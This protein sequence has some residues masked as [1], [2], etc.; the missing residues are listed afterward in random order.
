[1]SDDS[2]AQAFPGCMRAGGGPGAGLARSGQLGHRGGVYLDMPSCATRDGL[3]PAAA[4]KAIEAGWRA[5]ANLSQCD[6]LFC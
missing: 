6:L 1:M 2:L 3:R 5:N 4:S